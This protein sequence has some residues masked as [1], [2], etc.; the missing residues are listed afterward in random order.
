[1]DLGKEFIVKLSMGIAPSVMRKYFALTR[2]NPQ[3]KP[4]NLSLY[5]SEM[6]KNHKA[7]DFVELQKILKY[8]INWIFKSIASQKEEQFPE[9]WIKWTTNSTFYD[10]IA[11][12]IEAE[13]IDVAAIQAIEL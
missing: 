1:L 13:D 4:M 11:A 7:S 8:T 10:S 5:L 9:F 12:K 2:P 6:S 3:G